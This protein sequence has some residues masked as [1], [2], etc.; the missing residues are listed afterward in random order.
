MNTEFSSFT[1]LHEAIEHSC[2]ELRY[3]RQSRVDM[4][5]QLVGSHYSENG[6]DKRVPTNFIELAVTIYLRLLAARSPKALVTTESFP[7]RPFAKDIEIVLNQI[8]GEI[9]LGDTLQRAVLD[10]MFGFAVVKIGIANQGKSMIGVPYA[11]PFVDLV[12][13]DDYFCD[14]S[15][16][17]WKE[18]QF[19]GNE[20][21]MSVDDVNDVF[22]VNLDADEFNAQ[23]TTGDEQAKSIGMNTPGTP[24]R[25]K[26]LLRD[27]YVCSSG[28]LITYAVKSLKV[29]RDEPFDGPEGTPYLHLGFSKVPGNLMPLPPAMLW[30]DLHEL[31]NNL[32][33]KL[34]RQADSK[35]SVAT[36]SGG[37]DDDVRAL[38]AANDGDGIRYNG[39]KPEVIKVGGVDAPTLAFYLQTRDLFS[40]FAGNLD[41]LGGL[42]PQSDTL[43]QDK[44]LSEAANARVNSMS[45][46]VVDFCKA[47]FKRLAWYVWTD[48]IRERKF[49]KT[50]KGVSG[51]A[52]EKKWTPE[53][54]DG[55]FLDYNFS[56]D[57][58]SMQDDSPSTKVQKF[59]MVFERFLMPLAPM[60]QAQGAYIDVVKVMEFLSK[61]AAIPELDELV[62]FSQAMMEQNPVSG[63][64]NPEVASFKPSS[65][66]R[67]YERVNRPGGTRSGNDNILSKI[68]MGSNVQDA[69]GASVGRGVS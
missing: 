53:T 12:Q 63:N 37:N 61:N 32:F 48:P 41:V 36:F 56:I 59:G 69:E 27:V 49:H 33:R 16:K 34:A 45:E 18:I 7:L 1:R 25:D 62:K 22:G 55:D 19:E 21:L 24:L 43:G 8:P 38:K 46:A 44:L 3:P 17:S 26:V 6:S 68:L 28:K 65:T 51:I 14:M 40:Y 47:I 20:Y 9:D 31:G 42:S 66:T 30:I 67:R 35:K 64:P 5:R 13:I 2:T 52:I 57:V 23:S 15:A 11:E 58:Y 10:A 50:V 60:L 54:R 29:L 39:Q 4:I